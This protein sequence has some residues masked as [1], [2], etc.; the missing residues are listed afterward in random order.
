[1]KQEATNTFGE[2][3]IMD[4]NPLTTPNNVLT[5]ALNAT[6]ITYNGNE[7]V[8]QNDMGNG[9]VETA[10]LPSGYVPVGIKEYGGII[11]V[12]SYNP[13]TNKGQIGS[14]PSPERNISSSEIN[15]AEDPEIGSD[16]F[17]LSQGQYIYKFKLF[18]DTGNTV[19]R[20]GDKFSIIIT[21]DITI[22]SLKAFVSNCLNTTDGKINS[23]KNKLLTITVAVFDSNNNLRD[24][25]SQLKRFDNNN[26]V[27]EFDATTLPEIKYN[28]GYYMQC[29]PDSTITDDL[30][31]NFRERYAANTYNNK[32][33]GELY[34]ITKLNTITAVDVSVSGLK[35]LDKE[36]E[37]IDGI[38]VPK[39]SSLVIFDSV[40][41]YNCPDGYY[42]S[43]PSDMSDSMRNKYLSYYG[44]ESDFKNSNGDFSNFIRGVEFDLNIPSARSSDKFYLPFSVDQESSVPVYNEGS[45]LY[46]SEQSSGYV[47]ND[48]NSIINFKATPYMTFG[49]LSGLS[50]SGSINLNLLGSGIIEVNTW[51]YFCEQDNITIT[52]GLEAYPRTG[53]EIQEVKFIFYNALSTSPERTIL[54][55]PLARKRSY[56]GVFT[57]TLALGSNLRYGN[58]YLTRVV[59]TTIKGNVI[60]KYRWLLTTPLYNKLYFDVQDFGQDLS[61]ISEY[62]NVELS[63]S[64]SYG[65][66]NTS[67]T[68]TAPYSAL[69]NE[70]G[71]EQK[72]EV[73]QYTKYSSI[74][75]LK[76]STTLDNIRN[77]PFTLN[78]ESLNTT[79][80]LK[81]ATVSIPNMVYVGSMANIN[82]L[83]TYIH[84]N[85]KLSKSASI[86]WESFSSPEFTITMDKLTGR[87]DVNL[88]LVSGLISGTVLDTYT[89]ENPYQS[90]IDNG[91]KFNRIF[92]YDFLDENADKSP[93]AR[94]GVAFNVRKKAKTVWRHMPKFTKTSR[95][96]MEC[97][98]G[99]KDR[100]V[101]DNSDKG[102]QYL[103]NKTR[104][105]V[106]EVIDSYYGRRPLCIVVGNAGMINGDAHVKKDS[107]N[108]YDNLAPGVIDMTRV[109]MLWW[110]NG[111]SYDYV[112]SAMYWDGVR[113]AI[114]YTAVIY[115]LFKYV[116]LQFGESVTKPLFGPELITSTYNSKYSSTLQTTTVIY[117]DV[118]E[119]GRN[120]VFVTESGFFNETTIKENLQIIASSIEDTIDS[121]LLF[122]FVDFKLQPFSVEETSERTYLVQDMVDTYNRLQSIENKSALPIV[123]ITDEGVIFSD[124]LL[125]NQVYYYGKKGDEL[126]VYN[127]RIA[128]QP[129]YDLLQNLKIGKHEGRITLLSNPTGLM[130]RDFY[131]ERDGS[132]LCYV[133]I[134]VITFGSAVNSITRPNLSWINVT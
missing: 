60:N 76:D 16:K 93:I 130:T 90:F 18:G 42:K 36:T 41:K 86:D 74:I 96:Q 1:M 87:T 97:P 8:L 133:G 14:F 82:A 34:I 134:P 50:V 95:Y 101:G 11:Y 27:I 17:K 104:S 54:E 28:T 121:D 58:L 10:Y 89:F 25:T 94:V 26:E 57:E 55:Y 98:I 20:S 125:N 116:L 19:I 38:I 56:N 22:N 129:G 67:E 53:D 2:G 102:W 123:A 124:I 78:L 30:V 126:V 79:Y 52:W 107:N 118:T 85:S 83:D 119:E 110:Y 61:T 35:N 5:S 15:K 12:A 49:A 39:D 66:Q 40:Y 64:T 106:V 51:K 120:K 114:D 47:I 81:D 105:K 103:N 84:A 9:R 65:V 68:K 48:T 24:I 127:P 29:I 45:G 128:G 73:H 70:A 7:F 4:L 88:K 132:R 69:F 6:M 115:D 71:G 33:S 63:V 113:P 43:N 92:G 3:M 111:A 80:T 122:Q 23:P 44:I 72:I 31:S 131:T 59:I 109:E 62:N 75:E 108:G 117:K 46:E 112:Q 32:I 21:S 13:L 91:D 77:Y 37:D 100:N 99:D